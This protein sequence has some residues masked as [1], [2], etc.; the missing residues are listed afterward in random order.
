VHFR[1]SADP[2]HSWAIDSLKDAS[3]FHKHAPDIPTA[4][5]DT[6]KALG[7]RWTS[8]LASGKFKL[9]IPTTTPI[10]TPSAADFWTTQWSYQYL[11]EQASEL[12][13]TLRGSALVIFKGDLNYRK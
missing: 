12:C 7:E 2:G 10:G 9:S 6:L 11:P 1:C 3:F 13:E 5:L 8:H 4:D